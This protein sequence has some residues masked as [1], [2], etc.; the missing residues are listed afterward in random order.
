[1]DRDLI[2]C[3]LESIGLVWAATA[4]YSVP[5]VWAFQRGWC[6]YIDSMKDIGKPDDRGLS[7]VWGRD[8]TGKRCSW[9]RLSANWSFIIW[10]P[11]LVMDVDA[12][13]LHP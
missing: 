13:D 12:E 4:H 2:V 10:A 8:D 9:T 7:T 11:D 5:S 1:M 6:L 3:D